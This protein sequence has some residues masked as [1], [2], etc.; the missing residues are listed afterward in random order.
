MLDVLPRV[1][2]A[3]GSEGEGMKGIPVSY[4]VVPT[5][6]FVVLRVMGEHPNKKE[7]VK[8]VRAGTVK[9][10]RVRVPTQ[11]VWSKAI[12]KRRMVRT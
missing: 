12:V 5:S 9:G 4:V 10:V 1:S 7:L 11:V 6:G 3:V 2:G 8:A